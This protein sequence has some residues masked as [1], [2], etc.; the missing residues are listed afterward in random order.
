MI[1]ELKNSVTEAFSKRN[2]IDQNN[3]VF[4]YEDSQDCCEDWGWGVWNPK[5]KEKVADSPDGLPYHFDF[6]SG[7]TEIEFTDYLPKREYAKML[8]GQDQT[9]LDHL[10]VVRVNLLPDEG[11]EGEPLVFEAWTDHNGYYLHSFAFEKRDNNK[12]GKNNG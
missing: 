8:Y 6:E 1:K 10:D 4:G 5:T 9:Y 12:K 3:I 7:A 2:W 11:T